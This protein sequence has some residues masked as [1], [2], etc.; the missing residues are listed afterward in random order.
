MV[1]RGTP[2]PFKEP[3]KNRYGSVSWGEAGG[4]V[5]TVTAWRSKVRQVCKQELLQEE[6]PVPQDEPPAEFKEPQTNT[7]ICTRQKTE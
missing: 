1:L 3:F 6:P 7:K 2:K 4:R 5:T